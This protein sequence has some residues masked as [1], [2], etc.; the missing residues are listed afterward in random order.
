MELSDLH[1][2]VGDPSLDSVTFLNEVADRYPDAVSFA[3]GRPSEDFFRVGD[4]DRY[5]RRYCAFLASERGFDERRIV[6]TLFQYGRTKGITADLVARHLAVDEG[7]TADPESVVVTVGAQEA[8]LLVL[9]ALRRDGRDVALAV[10]P[11]YAGFTGAARLVD[12]PV[13]PVASGER[14]I[15]L[16]DLRERLRATRGEGLRPRCLYLV[17]DFSNPTGL[18]LDIPTRRRLLDVAARED[19]LLLEDNPYGHFTGR[20]DRLPTLKALDEEARVIYLGSFAK[21]ASPGVRVGFAVADQRVTVRGRTTG[22]LADELAKIKSMVTVNTSPISQAL[23]AGQLLEHDFSLYAANAEARA[24]YRRN[25]DLVCDGLR[26]RFPAGQAGEVRWNV[27]T[28]GFFV[29]L[30][31]PFR[32]DDEMLEHSARAHRVLWTPMGHFYPEP[33]A[34]DHQL[35]LS[36]S[37]LTPAEIGTGLDRLADLVAEQTRPETAETAE[38]AETVETAEVVRAG[39]RA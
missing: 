3:A 16:D 33:G 36:C 2:A 10:S 11:T 28:G 13:V 12:M 30:S 9:R 4:L 26:Q 31:V 7:I 23:V 5:L 21:T 38:V 1:A 27:P 25:L 14:G 19:L 8:M 17:P 29:V 6:R 15:D 22:Y 35:R 18:S 32:A 39:P 34:G 37:L 20:G 24:S